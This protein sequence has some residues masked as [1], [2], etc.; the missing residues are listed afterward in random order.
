M[1][2]HLPKQVLKS[3][4]VFFIDN[5]HAWPDDAV[6]SNGLVYWPDSGKYPGYT[7]VGLASHPEYDGK[8]VVQAGQLG[9][10]ATFIPGAQSIEDVKQGLKGKPEQYRIA[11]DG[12]V[13]A[14]MLAR[15]DTTGGAGD[16]NDATLLHLLA[17]VAPERAAVLQQALANFLRAP[18][19]E[20][21][22]NVTVAEE[23]HDVLA[24]ATTPLADPDAP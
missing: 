3:M 5:K 18:G 15:A 9:M 16:V 11:I 4:A 8:I 21:P 6:L 10:I 1:K 14:L 7:L 24:A 12:I 17:Q 13:Q 20:P 23:M 19:T 2:A 22:K